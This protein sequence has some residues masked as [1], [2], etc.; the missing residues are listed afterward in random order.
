MRKFLDGFYW[1][2]GFSIALVG[3][4][5]AYATVGHIQVERSYQESMDQL[6]VEN[7]DSFVDAL[8]LELTETKAV[9]N[10]ILLTTRM[11]NL[12]L[13][14]NS[15]GLA[16]RFSLYTSS[17]EFMGQCTETIPAIDSKEEKIDMLSICKTKLYPVSDFGKATVAVVK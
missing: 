3:V 15:F 11:S 17:G 10:E 8:E 7:M 13:T 12:G 9:D 4:F 5:A 2:L 14:P 1:G 6:Q 16:I